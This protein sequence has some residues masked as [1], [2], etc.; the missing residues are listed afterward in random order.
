M[1]VR[2]LY[3]H[4]VA[5]FGGASKS[6]CELYKAFPK[7][8]VCGTVITPKGSVV[9]Q[10]QS[11]G[12]DTIEVKGVSQFNHTFHGAYKGLRW[13]VL[14]RELMYI[15]FTVFGLIKAF[16][17]G[18]YDIIHLNDLTL[19]PLI[20]LLSLFSRS[21]IILTVRCVGISRGN[22]RNSWMRATLKKVDKI[23]A[24]D[25][26]V[27]KSILHLVEAPLVIHNG[28]NESLIGL[29]DKYKDKSSF[30]GCLHLGYVGNFLRNKG[31]FELLEVMASLKVSGVNNVKLNIFGEATRV[32]GSAIK[33]NVL[34]ILGVNVGIEEEINTFIDQNDIA[35]MIVFHG[36]VN[37][38]SKIYSKIDVLC[39]TSHL[40]APGRPVFE[41]A[42]WQVPSIVC[43]KKP[44]DDTIVHNETGICLPEPD[45]EKIKDA[46]I[47]LNSNR[48]LVVELGKNARKLAMDNFS[49]EKNSMEVLRQ[50]QELTD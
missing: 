50:Y 18:K 40:D 35:D 23:I 31:I 28:V 24:I 2:I 44:T 47:L 38:Y 20:P 22:I 7:E 46:V 8:R 12:L 25:E 26:T 30:K 13:L 17:K 5:S 34:K 27:A 15:P 29:S 4:P 3:I 16:K 48:G 10:F 42:F 32:S 21:K 39:F 37:E 19:F 6:L 43:V 11:V 1:F 41:A 14:L 9:S 36:F 49:Q 45:V 33:N